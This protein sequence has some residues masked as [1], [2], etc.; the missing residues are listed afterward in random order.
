MPS[1]AALFIKRA[2]IKNFH[3]AE[4][5]LAAQEIKGLSELEKENL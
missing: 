3:H 5:I 1:I 4:Q 2:S